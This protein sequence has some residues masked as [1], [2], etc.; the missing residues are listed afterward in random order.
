MA[1]CP[2][3]SSRPAKRFCPAKHEKI[4]ATC[5]GAKREV[6]IDCPGS[7][8]HLKAGRSYESEK[9]A[10]DPELAAQALEYSQGFTSRYGAVI[11]ALVDA[12][13]N[14]RAASPWMLDTDV[15]EVYKALSATMKTLSTGIYYETLPEGSVRLSLYRRLRSV[16][17]EFMRPSLEIDHDALKASEAVDVLGFMKF[18][19]TAKSNPRPK[20]RQYL[21]WLSEATGVHNDSPS[22]LIAP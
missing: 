17:D 21:D 18:T 10:F 9:R 16:L 11:D 3:C 4:C 14:E 19:A 15:L 8:P 12:V 2:L 5:C 13:M 1:S 7:C 22:R 6:E 20:S